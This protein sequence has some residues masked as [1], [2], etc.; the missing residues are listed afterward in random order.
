MIKERLSL[1]RKRVADAARRI[2]R[3]PNKIPIVAVSKVKPVADIVTAYEAGHRH[4]GESY[5]QEFQSK[6]EEL[7]PL[8]GA[9]FHMIGRLQSNK[10][11]QA[12]KFFDVIQTVDSEKLVRRLSDTGRNVD[13]FLEVK[14][15]GDEDRAGLV[16]ADIERGKRSVEN[17]PHINLRGLMGMPPWCDDPK[18]TR[19]YFQRLRYLAGQYELSE[20]SMGMSRDFEIAIEEGSTLVRVGTAIFGQRVHSR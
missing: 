15:S 17:C 8:P 16:E 9:I 1:I 11:K 4:F 2:G 19:P 14:L 18:H 5:I 20:L 7:P 10:T 12:S 3:D 13:I 6:R